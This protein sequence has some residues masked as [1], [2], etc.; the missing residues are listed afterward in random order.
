MD[1]Q[2]ELFPAMGPV[3]LSR[4]MTA[5]STR[6]KRPSTLLKPLPEKKHD[7]AYKSLEV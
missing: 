2:A 3:D 4:G 6:R 5:R 7:D 1:E